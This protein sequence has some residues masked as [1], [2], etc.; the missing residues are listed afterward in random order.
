MKN[1]ILSV[2]FLLLVFSARSQGL[3][4][5]TYEDYT[6]NKGI[7]VDASSFAFVPELSS[8][9]LKHAGQFKDIDPWGFRWQGKLFRFSRL[10]GPHTLEVIDSG[11]FIL[12]S[13]PAMSQSGRPYDILYLSKDLNSEVHRANIH[14][15]ERIAKIDPQYQ[16]L[17][18]YIDAADR[19]KDF[20]TIVKEFNKQA[21]KHK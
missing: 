3:V 5:N 6:R 13:F 7:A 19:K 20:T 9:S 12:Y 1:V 2:L 4:Y 18:D 10:K 16:V 14:D 8:M 15:P 17:A 11:Q 21:A